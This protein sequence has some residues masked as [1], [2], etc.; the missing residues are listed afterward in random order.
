MYHQVDQT[1]LSYPSKNNYRLPEGPPRKADETQL[2]TFRYQ[3]TESLDTDQY[4][5]DQKNTDKV[6]HNRKDWPKVVL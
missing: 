1:L 5:L 4:S 3:P 2:E 6:A